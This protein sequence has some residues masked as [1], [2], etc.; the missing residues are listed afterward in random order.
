MKKKT[1]NNI[2]PILACCLAVVL[3]IGGLGKFLS[4]SFPTKNPSTPSI[5]EKPTCLH[6]EVVGGGILNADTVDEQIEFV[7]TSC[8]ES[9]FY[10]TS[11]A[12]KNNFPSYVEQITLETA[13]DGTA[14]EKKVYTPTYSG[15]WSVGFMNATTFVPFNSFYQASK[16]WLTH[17][18]GATKGL[19]RVSGGEGATDYWNW[20][21]FGLAWDANQGTTPVAINYQVEQ[22]GTVALSASSVRFSNTAEKYEINVLLNGN[23]LLN[24][25]VLIGSTANG[26]INTKD[27]LNAL[28]SSKGLDS[29]HVNFGDQLSFVARAVDG[30]SVAASMALPVVEYVGFDH[31]IGPCDG[32]AHTYEDGICRVCGKDISVYVVSGTWTLND[33]ITLPEHSMTQNVSFGITTSLEA[34]ADTPSMLCTAII[35]DVDAE[36]ISFVY[37]G[38]ASVVW[39]EGAWLDS[40]EELRTLDFGTLDQHLSEAFYAWFTANATPG[41][42]IVA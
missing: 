21:A 32:N 9:V 17:D 37:A 34:L 19:F 20:M 5:D 31:E 6:T 29:I 42:T 38:T 35:V 7:C 24:E 18:N 27:D 23:P 4:V 14:T 40:S 28:L 36:T 39:S 33:T 3:L 26:G 16:T 1:K 2:F 30:S 8:G 41:S 11:S 15:N 13:E 25:W 22:P 12:F 10:K